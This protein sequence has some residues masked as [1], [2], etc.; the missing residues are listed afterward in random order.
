M[1]VVIGADAALLALAF[2]MAVLM[3]GAVDLPP[4]SPD[5][6]PLRYALVAGAVIPGLLG[7]FWLRGA[8]ARQNLLGGP[9]E[10]ARVASGC[11]YGTLLAIAGSYL[12][13]AGPLV[14]R[15]WLL[16][17]WCMA[18]LLAG[19]GR[20]ALRRAAYRLRRRG[21][22]VRRALIAGASDQGLA[23]AQQ[24]HGP[25]RHGIEVVGLL[26]DYLA[27]GT[28]VGD[29]GRAQHVQSWV[30]F[31][32][33]GH[34][35]D[36][37]RVAIRHQC[38]LL[39]V[40]PP[41]LSWESQQ[42]LA[43]LGATVN[44]GLEVRLAPT[45]YDLTV[46]G[47]QAAPL[48]YIPLVRLQ[49]L[50]ITGI[51]AVLQSIID[52]GLAALLLVGLAPALACV[53]ARAHWRGVRPILVGGRVL[54]QG[55]KQVTLKLLNPRVSQ[56]LLLRGLPALIEVLR[57]RLALAGPQPVPAEEEAS[58]Q[59]WSG[60]LFAVKPGLTGCWRLIGPTASPEER[61]LAD[62]WWVRNWSI[63]QHL[64]VLLQTAYR[65]RAGAD[66]DR[67]VARWRTVEGPAK[68]A[69]RLIL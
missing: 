26:D 6:D 35:R 17:F 49:P 38:D 4:S 43:Q 8:Y 44:S 22:Y 23:I 15:G 64:F 67:H 3:R 53:I 58:Y 46:V 2:A 5:L 31:Q 60:V 19:T 42:S 59:R 52:V 10:Y 47:V 48:A 54:G 16:L 65:I 41:A 30:E 32:V 12:N 28:R 34:P 63:W 57:G 62:V 33:L 25:V 24:L 18:I 11:T 40:V 7:I 56:H 13:G 61:T 27:A 20:F 1:V 66:S 51:D 45:G 9:D 50:R 39:I 21:W 14:S 69:T 29:I 55:G 68:A 37:E 36:A